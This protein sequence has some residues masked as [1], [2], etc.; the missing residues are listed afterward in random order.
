MQS[1]I[2]RDESSCQHGVICVAVQQR[3]PWGLV[4]EGEV[5]GRRGDEL[6][7]ELQTANNLT[8]LFSHTV[9]EAPHSI[10]V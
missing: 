6:L 1:P 4:E 8:L 2:A 9:E 5:A 7:L 3:G 10:L